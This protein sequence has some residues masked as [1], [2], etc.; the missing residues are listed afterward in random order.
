[1]GAREAEIYARGFVGLLTRR[2][3]TVGVC[4]L[5]GTTR[6]DYENTGFLGCPLC[7]DA[8]G[9]LNPPAASSE[10]EAEPRTS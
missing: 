6:A 7:Y 2:P 4:P 8:L 5:C 9:I 10:S 3:R 1:M